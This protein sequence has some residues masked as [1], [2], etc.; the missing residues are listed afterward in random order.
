[1]HTY[2]K[3]SINKNS[4]HRLIDT[5]SRQQRM[6]R[7]ETMLFTENSNL[8][9][10]SMAISS[11]NTIL[12][13]YTTEHLSTHQQIGKFKKDKRM[14]TERKTCRD[15]ELDHWQWQWLECLILCCCS[16]ETQQPPQHP[17]SESPATHTNWC[18]QLTLLSAP[19]THTN[20]THNNHHFTAIIQVNLY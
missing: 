20:N 13:L 3:E 14:Y 2:I 11:S 12:Q 9:R 5:V 4:D 18:Y 10:H 15:N 1:M 17:A 6:Q 8:H 7:P 16:A 19:V